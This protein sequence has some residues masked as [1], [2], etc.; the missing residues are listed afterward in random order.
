MAF[1]K[2]MIEENIKPR[3]DILGLIPGILLT[4]VISVAALYINKFYKPVSA[5]AVAIIAGVLIRNLF[6]LPEKC[7]TGQTMVAK[8]IIKWGIILLGVRLSFAEVLK[9]GGSA[10][11]IIVSCITLAILLVRYISV[12]IGLPDRLGTLISVGTSICGVS[13]IVAT[14]PAIGANEEETAFAVATITIFGLLAVIVYPVIGH[15]LHMSDVCFGTWTGTAVNDTSQVVAT[16]FIYSDAAGKVATVVKLT[17]NLFMAPVIVILSSFYMMKKAKE[18]QQT[19]EK[20]KMDYRKTFPLFVLGFIV[21]AILRTL[22]IFSHEGISMIK[23]IANFLIVTAIA[24]V[25]LGTSFASMKKVGLKSFYAGLFA[26]VLMASASL[27][28]I[29]LLAI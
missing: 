6:G 11:V 17:R 18:G 7:R 14:S 20:K 1:K 25:G 28:L 5:V 4:L 24:G 9:I 12:K 29:K 10:L 15:L 22:G 2:D 13:A 27:A 3:I 8:N 19:I 21:M 16:G 23:A 26:S